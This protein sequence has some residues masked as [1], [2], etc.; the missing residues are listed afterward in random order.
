MGAKYNAFTKGMA[1]LVN[2][3]HMRIN[4]LDN[5]GRRRKTPV[6]ITAMQRYIAAPG[7]PPFSATNLKR[8]AM[9][10][11]HQRTVLMPSP[12]IEAAEKRHRETPS[13]PLMENKR[14]RIETPLVDP[15]PL[16][17]ITA[18]LWFCAI[19]V[20]LNKQL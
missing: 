7:E 19:L 14:R 3:M 13:E 15:T 20:Q 4:S 12:R 16:Y 11:R 9:G 1:R 6:H 5:A 18:T 2:L 8:A 17:G 10:F